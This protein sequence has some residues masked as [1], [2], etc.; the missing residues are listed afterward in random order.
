M[1]FFS[2]GTEFRRC[3]VD[4]Y[5]IQKLMGY[6]GI[7]VASELYVHNEAEELKKAMGIVC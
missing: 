1:L 7:K 4:I 2:N 5:T 6:R 3:G